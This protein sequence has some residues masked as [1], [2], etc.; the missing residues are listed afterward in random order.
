MASR[1][2]QSRVRQQ[3]V[4]AA[5]ERIIAAARELLEQSGRPGAEP[6]TIDA[7]ARR[8]GSARMTV[9]N[10]FASKAGLLEAL[11][12]DLAEEGE[13]ARMPEVFAERN[14]WTALDRLVEVFGRFWT[15]HRQVH[16][17]LAVA[18]AQDPDLA[19]A[20]A[21]RNE[22]RRRGLAEL[23]RRMPAKHVAALPRDDVLQALFV[24]LSFSTFDA[25]A[26]EGRSPEEI[27]PMVQRIV[28]LVTGAPD[29]G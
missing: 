22:R 24:L 12:D 5:R 29:A 13:M 16:R 26:S 25:L 11:F 15:V 28:R 23:L 20:L 4:E 14:A 17:G 21:Q 27:V 18:A 8:A 7:V 2:Y 10:Q 19:A 9:Y 3:S 1:P 6:F